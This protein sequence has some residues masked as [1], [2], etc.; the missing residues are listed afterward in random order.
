MRIVEFLVSMPDAGLGQALGQDARP[1]MQVVLIAP[2]AVDVD[3]LQALEAGAVLRHQ[4]DRVVR[5]PALPARLDALA[6]FQ[7]VRQPEAVR[8][9]RV[10]I[11]RGR[12]AQ[13]H[14]AVDLG[15]R[16]A[17]ALVERP[18]ETPHAAVVVTG[19][20][21]ALAARYVHGPRPARRAPGTWQARPACW[22][23]RVP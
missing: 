10:R 13:V 19:A 15:L 17:A 8:C 23:S 7:V 21:A 6:R 12:H 1:V 9:A 2:A 5:E 20:G 14:D 4:V 22:A 16:R 18:Q 3:A 11:V